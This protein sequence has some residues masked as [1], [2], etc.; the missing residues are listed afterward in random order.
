MYLR[1]APKVLIKKSRQFRKDTDVKITI[2]TRQCRFSCLFVL[3]LGLQCTLIH[4]QSFP[5]RFEEIKKN[6]SKEQLYAFLFDLPKGGDLH[7]HLGLSIPA[8]WWYEA[9][10]DRSRPHANEFYTRTKFNNC[11]DSTEPLVR[12]RTIQKSTYEQF[13]S[14]RKSEYE[15]LAALSPVLKQQWIS[16][17]KLDAEGEG[18]NEFFEVIGARINE[19][20]RDPYLIADGLVEN[21]KRFGAEGLRYLET[22]G[23]ASYFWDKDGNLIDTEKGVQIIRDRLNQPDAKTSGVTV[24]FQSMFIRFAPRAEEQ[25][26]NTYVFVDKHR[27]LWVGINMAGREDND[28]G[29][30][31][32][33]LDTFRKMRRTYSGIG[34]SL[35]AGESQSPNHSVRDTLLLGATRIGHGINLINDP[36]TMLLMRSGKFLVEINLISNR[37]LEY[38]PDVRK[39]PFPEYLRLGIPVCLNTDDRGSWDSNM[40]DEYFTAVTSFNLTWDEIVQMGRNSLSFSFAEQPLKQRLLDEYDAAIIA[41]E[42]KYG[43]DQWAKT[44]S[45]VQ[46]ISSGYAAR[47]FG[48]NLGSR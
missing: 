13:S 8:D 45:K 14:C 43:D 25:L 12:F 19:L 47:S 5:H 16:A 1:D 26:E 4:G 48:I 29:Y 7:N 36:D 24:R 10:T 11:P 6:S 15:P 37:L 42:K 41:F 35:H 18:R 9:A 34:I 20:S 30:P 32:R 2:L 38:V 21:M 33:F 17:I 23:G 22:Q 39:H 3:Y 40:T 28:S 27:D 31:L 46:P 44:L